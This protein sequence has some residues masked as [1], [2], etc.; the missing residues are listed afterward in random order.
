MKNKDEIYV[1][2]NRTDTSQIPEEKLTSISEKGLYQALKNLDLYGI[3]V[4]FG[5]MYYFW[6]RDYIDFEEIKKINKMNEEDFQK[7]LDNLILNGF[8]KE[9]TNGNF[10]FNDVLEEFDV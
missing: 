10:V 2:V 5:V 7:G 4:Y 8:V 1:Y 9:D 6:S 3:K